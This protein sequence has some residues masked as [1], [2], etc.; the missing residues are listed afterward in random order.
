MR[1]RPPVPVARRTWAAAAALAL[2][3]SAAAATGAPPVV[4]AAPALDPAC[5]SAPERPASRAVAPASV[6]ADLPAP[7]AYRPNETEQA[8]ALAEATTVVTKQAAELGLDGCYREKPREIA[9]R[10]DLLSPFEFL[11]YSTFD[12]DLQ[13]RDALLEQYRTDPRGAIKNLG[14]AFPSTRAQAALASYA[15]YDVSSDRIRVNAEHVPSAE[16]RR[17]L[18][19]EFWHAMPKARRWSEGEGRLLRAS[20]FWLQEQPAGR[21]IWLPVEDRRG[22][23]YASYLLDEAM[24]TLMETR[25]AGPSKHARPDLLEV[26]G[27]LDKLMSVAGR[28]D[29]LDA[30]LGSEPEA[31]AALTQ[32]HRAEFPELEVLARP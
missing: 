32:A 31:L 28:D 17:V 19:H 11:V 5:A 29:V 10:V 27:Y 2:L 22:L 23:P 1:A 12:A 6:A 16:L 9:G 3:A 25:Y 15:Y 7:F 8:A 4:L 18:V 21:R 24:A 20:G 14:D 30:Y 13:K 26:Q